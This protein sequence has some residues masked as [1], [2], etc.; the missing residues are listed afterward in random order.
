MSLTITISSYLTGKRAPLTTLRTS[1]WYPLVRKRK[2]F[3]TRSGVRARPSRP[4]SSTSCPI[5]L[6]IR[7]ANELPSMSRAGIFTTRFCLAIHLRHF[8]DV[9]RRLGDANFIEHGPGA[10]KCRVPVC[11]QA[12][13]DLARQVLG[14]RHHL[15]KCSALGVQILVVECVEYLLLHYPVEGGRIDGSAGTRIERA[16]RAH[17]HLVIVAVAVWVIALAVQAGVFGVG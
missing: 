9:A 13:V 3:S 14:S 1:V 15:P 4:G 6:R 16:T 8:K 5:I 12:G 17:L 7:G 2:A 11:P 10:W